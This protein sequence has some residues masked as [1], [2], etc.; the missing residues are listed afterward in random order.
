MGRDY[1][2]VVLNVFLDMD[3]KRRATAFQK[4]DANLEFGVDI[5]YVGDGLVG[6]DEGIDPFTGESYATVCMGKAAATGGAK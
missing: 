5:S 1:D 6:H 3:G 4:S 2:E